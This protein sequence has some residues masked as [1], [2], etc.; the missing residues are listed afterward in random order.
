M[1][2]VPDNEGAFG[3]DVAAG[4]R[5]RRLRWHRGPALRPP[6]R[7]ADLQPLYK[8]ARPVLMAARP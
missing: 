5:G 4:H 8:A 1:T 7:L 6:H 3:R 2:G